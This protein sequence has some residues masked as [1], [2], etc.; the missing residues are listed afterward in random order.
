VFKKIIKTFQKNKKIKFTYLYNFKNLIKT[1]NNCKY[2]IGNESGPICIGAALNKIILS[3]FY[4]KH[5]PQSSKTINKKVKYFNTDLVSS[6]KIIT[7]II[8]IIK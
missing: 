1:M 8:K 5:T 2:I 4:P 3:I 6:Q 7:K